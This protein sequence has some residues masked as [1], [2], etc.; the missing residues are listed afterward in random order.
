[1]D[2]IMTRK[3]VTLSNSRSYVVLDQVNLNNAIYCFI[4][5]LIDDNTFI[6]VEKEEINDQ[7][8]FKLI[9]DINLENKLKD[10]FARKLGLEV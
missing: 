3:L 5:D 9:D 7:A 1:M 6:I 10:L 2:D 8:I 4:A